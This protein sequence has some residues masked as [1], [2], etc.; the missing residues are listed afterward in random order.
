MKVDEIWA[1]EDYCILIVD[2]FPDD[3]W[4]VA[5]FNMLDGLEKTVKIIRGRDSGWACNYETGDN[6]RKHYRKVY[7]NR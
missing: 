3:N 6:I 2:K 5:P 1:N 7:E 4:G